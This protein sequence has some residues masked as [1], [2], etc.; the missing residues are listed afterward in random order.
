VEY[1]ELLRQRV[2]RAGAQVWLVNTGW[3]GGPYGEGRRIPIADT[4]RIVRA[5]L[6]DELA[7]TPCVAEPW[8]GLQVP[9]A[10]PGISRSMLDVRS[11]WSDAARYDEQALALARRF[12]ENFASYRASVP[13]A[14]S[15]AGPI[16]AEAERL[17]RRD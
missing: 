7:L 3:M 5:I 17:A 2:A 11:G 10:V 9:L 6:N 15:H 8:F 13:Y 14:V 4:R 16:P 12:D 1:A